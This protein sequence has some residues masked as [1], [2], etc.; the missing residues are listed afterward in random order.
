MLFEQFNVFK[1]IAEIKFTIFVLVP[2]SIPATTATTNWK[3]H[4]LSAIII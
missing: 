4:A 2:I 3:E 1:F